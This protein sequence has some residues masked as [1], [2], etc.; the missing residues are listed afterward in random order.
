[1]RKPRL[2]SIQSTHA[3]ECEQVLAELLELA[4]AGRVTGLTWAIV[5]DDR[6]IRFG[7]VGLM[8][9]N[10]GLAMLSL[11][12]KAARIINSQTPK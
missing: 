11:M 6:E 7:R 3:R 12:R 1:M 10:A 9:R 8:G 4:K 2:Y 5:T